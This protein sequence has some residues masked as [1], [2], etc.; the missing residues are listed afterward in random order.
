ML[1]PI[2]RTRQNYR[3][4]AAERFFAQAVCGDDIAKAARAIAAPLNQHLPS[5]SAKLRRLGIVPAARRILDA[6]SEIVSRQCVRIGAHP[7]QDRYEI[8]ID[9]SPLCPI[10]SS[11]RTCPPGRDTR[12]QSSAGFHGAQN[13]IG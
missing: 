3:G 7:R 5:L 13:R 10:E 11:F 4:W 1:R 9:E 2:R 6:K 12:S 8:G